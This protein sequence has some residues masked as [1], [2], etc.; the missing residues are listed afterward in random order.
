MAARLLSLAS[1]LAITGSLVGCGAD[2]HGLSRVGFPT[3]RLS[4]S[5][6]AAWER[7]DCSG[8]RGGPFVSPFTYLSTLKTLRSA[9][10][11]GFQGPPPSLSR[12][13]TDG[14]FIVWSWWDLPMPINFS[15]LPGQPLTVGGQAARFRTIRRGSVYWRE[16]RCGRVGG[17]KEIVAIS[18]G[19]SHTYF[20]MAACLRGPAF[21]RSE[22]AIRKMLAT[23]SFSG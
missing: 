20:S 2:A 19:S 13:G 1:V 11:C 14:V 16:S 18:G 15:R 9:A 4:F 3:Y 23:V 12:L 8:H 6:P 5:Y 21:A 10:V 22:D 7:V 17:Q